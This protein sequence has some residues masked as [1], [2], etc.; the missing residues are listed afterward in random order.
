MKEVPHLI[1]AYCRRWRISRS[2]LDFLQHMHAR[3]TKSVLYQRIIYF[4]TCVL[5]ESLL[6]DKYLKKE[7]ISD[8]SIEF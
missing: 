8:V 1:M 3:L 7:Y 4:L 5:W 2:E 6:S